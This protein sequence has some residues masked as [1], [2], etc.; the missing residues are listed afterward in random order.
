VKLSVAGSIACP[1]RPREAPIALGIYDA[2]TG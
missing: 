1:A 2:A